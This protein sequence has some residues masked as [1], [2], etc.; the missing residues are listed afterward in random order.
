M[1]F[2][3]R[4]VVALWT[5]SVCVGGVPQLNSVVLP[6]PSN[7]FLRNSI[8]VSEQ[9]TILHGS[10]SVLSADVRVT[11]ALCTNTIQSVTVPL[12]DGPWMFCEKVFLQSHNE[13]TSRD[14][15]LE[16]L[17]NLSFIM[18]VEVLDIEKTVTR[19]EITR[20]EQANNAELRDVANL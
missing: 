2:Y 14:F 5:A 1:T 4:C 11:G 7:G 20:K 6:F 12:C 13:T 18:L 17:E 19:C 8:F 16:K 3:Q 9:K 15:F 10:R